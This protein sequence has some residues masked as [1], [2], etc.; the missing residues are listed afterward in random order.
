MTLLI[1]PNIGSGSGSDEPILKVDHERE[2]Y[3]SDTVDRGELTFLSKCS[4]MY[5]TSSLRTFLRLRSVSSD[6]L[7]SSTA[8]TMLSNNR[9]TFTMRNPS[10]VPSVCDGRLGSYPIIK[11]DGEMKIQNVLP[12]HVESV[13]MNCWIT[14]NHLDEMLGHHDNRSRI[15]HSGSLRKMM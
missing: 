11:E 5:S 10:L 15:G 2:T 9:A 1:Q 3:T 14:G 7:F 6:G 12:E 4:S 8:S 13:F